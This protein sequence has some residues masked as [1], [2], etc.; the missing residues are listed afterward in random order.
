MP[1]SP[2]P[3]YT[4]PTTRYKSAKPLP[5]GL[6]AGNHAR[7]A[8]ACPHLPLV[9]MLVLSQLAV[10][11][12]TAA[13][14]L[15]PARWLALVA[16]VSGL[17]AVGIGAL[18]LGQPLKAWRA[19]LGWRASWFSREVI[20]FGAFVPLAGLAAA[21]CWFAPLA[22]LRKPLLLAACASGLLGVACSAMIYADTRREFWRASQSFG[23]FFSTTLLLGAVSALVISGG[24]AAPLVALLGLVTV[25]KLGL[26]NRIFQHLVDEETLAAPSS[27]NKTARLLAGQLGLFARLRIPCG[28]VGGVFLPILLAVEFAP[29]DSHGRWLAFTAAAFC[30]AGE[31]LE[32]YLFFTAVAPAKM[33]GGLTA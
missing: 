26:E 33:P 3:D 31:L 8:P 29:G 19:F 15:E 4:V 17:L 12:S 16:A 28:L 1:C 27:L 30:L 11:A 20:V 24:Q 22:P 18:H 25:F 13:A 9:F 23:K 32:R 21:S 5:A 14:F 10:G 2:D 7:V 6:L